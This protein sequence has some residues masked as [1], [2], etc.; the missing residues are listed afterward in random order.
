MLVVC[1]IKEWLFV[2]G[3]NVLPVPF[4]AAAGAGSGEPA[5]A[6]P[7]PA[8]DSSH[9]GDVRF[10]EWSWRVQTGA[11]AQC[12]TS[13][14]GGGAAVNSPHQR[15]THSTAQCAHTHKHTRTSVSPSN[16]ASLSS[17]RRTLGVLPTNSPCVYT[18]VFR[19]TAMVVGSS[20]A[21]ART[22]P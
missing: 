16:A 10:R 5:T 13:V 4:R 3:R 8:P 11:R 22:P 2:G 19:S 7:R 15:A 14:A 20:D 17:Y 9:D 12:T 18:Y 21:M 1:A 6:S